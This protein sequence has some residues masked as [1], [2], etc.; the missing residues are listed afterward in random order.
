V[1]GGGAGDGIVETVP[2]QSIETPCVNICAIDEGTGWCVG[3]G[4]TIDEIAKWSSGSSTWRHDV[5]AALPER[6]RS[7]L[8]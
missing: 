4:R 6:M 3:C 5:M 8:T 2:V 7:R 1:D